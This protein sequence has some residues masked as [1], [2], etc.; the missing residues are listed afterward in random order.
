MKDDTPTRAERI[1]QKSA[2]RRE[3]QKEALRQAILAAAGELFLAHG[4][5]GFSLRQVA[6]RVGYSP[7]TIY[8]YFA[9]KDEL[10][11]TVVLEGFERFGRMLEEAYASTNEHSARLEALGRAYIRFGL[12]NPTHYRLMFM[13]R[14]EFLLRPRPGGRKPTIDSFG[15][16]FRAVEEA[17]AEGVLKP[18]EPLV[19]AQLLWAGVHGIVALALNMPD[20]DE[21]RAWQLADLYFPAIFKGLSKR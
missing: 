14:S 11:F 10:L 7:T 20:C 6:E 3:K 13:Q 17:L 12:E 5:E 2:L 16:L 1:R 18:T 8:L 19:V 15:V 9:D 4:Y 21:V